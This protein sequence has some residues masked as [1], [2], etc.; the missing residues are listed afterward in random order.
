MAFI[1]DI[2]NF[3]T[4][5]VDR[6][7]KSF[8]MARRNAVRNKV[9]RTTYEELSAL[10]QRDLDDLGIARESIRDIAREAARSA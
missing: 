2:Q 8:D 6:M 10:S 9:Y 1:T 5:L 4:G 7:R 3:E